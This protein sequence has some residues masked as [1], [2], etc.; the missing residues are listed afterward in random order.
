MATAIHIQP[1]IRHKGNHVS[2]PRFE[3]GRQTGND[4]L[5]LWTRPRQVIAGRAIV[6]LPQIPRLNDIAKWLTP[7]PEFALAG[8]GPGESRKPPA[9][10]T[11]GATTL[12]SSGSGPTGGNDDDVYAEEG[13]DDEPYF[14]EDPEP[15]P[16]QTRRSAGAQRQSAAASGGAAGGSGGGGRQRTVQYQPEERYWTEYLRIALPILGLLLMIALLWYW[17]LQLTGDDNNGND[18]IETPPGTTEVLTPP[19]VEPTDEIVVPPTTEPDA[20]TPVA[21]EETP[22]VED[23]PEPEE[24]TAE[25][26]AEGAAVQV[27]DDGVNMRADA[28]TDSEAVIQLNQG[29]VLTVLSGPVEGDN[30]I[31]WEVVV[32]ESGDTGY[33]AED[34]IEVV[35]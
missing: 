18:P 12:F 30:Y 31:W 7:S 11:K 24:T 20:S 4:V 29:D 1:S 28:T 10:P 15:E 34:F 5:A 17:A 21:E 23:T 9:I 22:V 3:F 19:T 25:E 13:Y 35:P 14:D 27:T 16:Q 32:E 26:I 33:V 2:L 8:A 6:K